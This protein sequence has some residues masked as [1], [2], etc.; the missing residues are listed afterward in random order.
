MFSSVIL[1]QLHQGSLFTVSVMLTKVTVFNFI[2]SMY[3]E[4][5]RIGETLNEDIVTFD[6]VTNGGEPV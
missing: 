5:D 4:D 1:R 3:A 6:Q 2:I